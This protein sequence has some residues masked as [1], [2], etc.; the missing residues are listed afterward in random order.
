[1]QPFPRTNTEKLVLD[2]FEGH[3]SQFLA[4]LEALSDPSRRICQSSPPHLDISEGGDILMDV[5]GELVLGNFFN[6]FGF[7]HTS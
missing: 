4:I 1:M 2:M 7:P 3:A 6:K 5:W